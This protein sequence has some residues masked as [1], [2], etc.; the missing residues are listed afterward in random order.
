MAHNNK[1]NAHRGPTWQGLYVRK[2]KTFKEKKAQEE[3][4]QKQRGWE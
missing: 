4:K 3:R 2:T 1:K